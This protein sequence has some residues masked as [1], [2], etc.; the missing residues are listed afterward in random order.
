MATL[1]LTEKAKA[2][3]RPSRAGSGSDSRSPWPSSTIPKS[4]SWTSRRRDWIPKP[5]AICG[6][7][8]AAIREEGRTVILT[9]HYMDEA[10]QLCDR[11]AI[12]DHGEVIALDTPG[13]LIETYAPGAKIHLRLSETGGHGALHDLPAVERIDANED[14]VVLYSNQP[15]M[16]LPAL[17][18]RLKGDGAGFSGLRVETGTL[19]DVFLRLTGRS[20]RE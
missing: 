13:A 5:G 9:T 6:T 11:I 2:R 3:L 16:S 19:E 7:W 12:M 14:G 20:L 1:N 8:C 15:H 18:E 17:F 4:S 10:E